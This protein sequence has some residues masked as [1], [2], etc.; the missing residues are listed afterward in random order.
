MMRNFKVET[1]VSISCV[2]NFVYTAKKETFAATDTKTSL[3]NQS[4]ILSYRAFSSKEFAGMIYNDEYSGNT[5]EAGQETVSMDLCNIWRNQ[6]YGGSF[7][8]YWDGKRVNELEISSTIS[9]KYLPFIT[10]EF[11][12][13]ALM[14]LPSDFPVRGPK[15][16]HSDIVEFEGQ[17][18][19]GNW[20]YENNWKHIPIYNTTDPFAAY[21]GEEIIRCNG[22]TVYWHGYHGGFLRDKYFPIV[23]TE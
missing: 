17:I 23:L 20:E 14:Q 10:I 1:A 16:F 5:V 15:Y 4:S 19:Y 6:Y 13:Q 8:Q 11:L 21:Q 12:K 9:I 18:Y 7:L 2:K 22:I 3:T